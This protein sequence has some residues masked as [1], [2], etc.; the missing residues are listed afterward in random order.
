M[1]S[2][3]LGC[4]PRTQGAVLELRVQPWNSGSCPGTWGPVLEL[5]VLFWNLGVL[6]WNLGCYPDQRSRY[7]K[8]HQITCVLK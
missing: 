7:K 8:L 4:H 3:N 2:W 6:S 5:G 1:P